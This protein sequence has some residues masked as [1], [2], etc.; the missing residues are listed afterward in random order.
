MCVYNNLA[1][2]ILIYSSQFQKY[3]VILKYILMNEINLKLLKQ[4]PFHYNIMI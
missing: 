1:I 4:Y 3:I 2:T